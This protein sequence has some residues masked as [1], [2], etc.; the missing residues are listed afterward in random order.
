LGPIDLANLSSWDLLLTQPE[1]A[2]GQRIADQLNN[3]PFIAINMGGKA[4]ENDWGEE[5]W[6]ELLRRLTLAFT[7]MGLLIVGSTEDLA[8]ASTAATCW[9]GAVV[10]ACGSLSPRES[11]AALHGASLFIGHDSGPLHLSAAC[12]VPCIGLF[13]DLHR[14][15]VWHPYGSMHRSI[16]CTSGMSGI[17]VDQVF[18]TAALLLSA[19]AKEF[20]LVKAT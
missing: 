16:H 13:G 14:P 3:G 12:G 20:K 9:Q 17:S 10:N 7:N 15:R 5:R 4:V 1:L 18:E 2:V 19:S 8:R 11:A 6:T